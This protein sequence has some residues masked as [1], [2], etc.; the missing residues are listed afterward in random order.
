MNWRNPQSGTYATDC[1]RESKAMEAAQTLNVGHS[2][3]CLSTDHLSGSELC[4]EVIARKKG[5]NT[6]CVSD[7]AHTKSA[8]DAVNNLRAGNG[9]HKKQSD[10]GGGNTCAAVIAAAAG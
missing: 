4:T 10:H 1:Y 9:Y 2:V 8:I 7:A 5:D 6:K 3:V